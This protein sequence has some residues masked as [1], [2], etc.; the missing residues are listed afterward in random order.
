MSHGARSI[1]LPSRTRRDGI[2]ARARVRGEYLGTDADRHPLDLGVF[3]RVPEAVKALPGRYPLPAP[4]TVDLLDELID[5]AP[6]WTKDAV[7]ILD[8]DDP[9]GDGLR[10]ARPQPQT[11]APAAGGELRLQRGR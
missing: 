3:A 7:R 1:G 9:D 8:G 5:D 2:L 10:G 6:R 11:A 4:L